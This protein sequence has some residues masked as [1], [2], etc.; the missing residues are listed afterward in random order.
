MPFDVL[1]ALNPPLLV[2]PKSECANIA[3]STTNQCSRCADK[4]NTWNYT[5]TR[6]LQD[7][8]NSCLRRVIAILCPETITRNCGWVGYTL[9]KG[10]ILR[11]HKHC[12]TVTGI[13]CPMLWL[14]RQ[15]SNQFF[16]I[17][18]NYHIV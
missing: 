8:I 18:S 14:I 4:C 15:N 10:D 6:K 9:R 3:T 16:S 7:F 13:I 1:T 11:Q 12:L 5:V 2:G 17:L